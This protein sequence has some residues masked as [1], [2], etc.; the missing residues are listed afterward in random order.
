LN[1]ITKS[2]RLV[3]T[4]VRWHTNTYTGVVCHIDPS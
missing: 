3:V 2:A 1:G 4:Y